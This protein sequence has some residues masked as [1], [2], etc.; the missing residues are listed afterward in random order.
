MLKEIRN[1]LN[2]IG[3]RE[4]YMT[5]KVSMT[6]K[7]EDDLQSYF[8]Q[9]KIKY[10]LDT[11]GKYA[12]TK[13]R[14]YLK[15]P[16]FLELPPK[17]SFFYGNC[18]H[19]RILENKDLLEEFPLVLTDSEIK[20]LDAITKVA[21]KNPMVKN[22]VKNKKFVEK[23][24]L[25][26]LKI[27]NGKIVKCKST[28]DVFTKDGILVDFKTTKSLEFK[29]G[30]HEIEN[31]P[32]ET[33]KKII[34]KYR[35]DLQIAFY[36]KALESIGEKVK[37]CVNV[38]LEKVPPYDIGFCYFSNETLRCGEFGDGGYNDGYLDA[39]EEMEDRPKKSNWSKI[40]RV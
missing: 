10:R 7:R 34:F 37:Y 13:I 20:S 33:L 3:I 35:Y 2:L 1:Y 11:K 4:V 17:K 15:N 32:S 28:I 9:D 36:K 18:L 40:V 31:L 22:I 25:F 27:P 29:W 30:W 21:K 16:R 6:K 23:T 12:T 19:S 26:D 8:N 5:K 24:I 14:N 39:I 38:F